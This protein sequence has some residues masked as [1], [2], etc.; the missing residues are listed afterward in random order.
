MVELAPEIVALLLLAG[1]AAGCIDA[2]A[3][4]GGLI[5]V[6]VL[7]FSGMSPVAALATN[8]LQASFGSTTAA[9]FFVRHKHIDL[10]TMWPAIM[11]AALGS[12]LGTGLIQLISTDWLMRFIP[13]LL[14]AVSVYLWCQKDTGHEAYDA[15]MKTSTFDRSFTLGIGAYDGFAGPGTGTF[16]TVTQRHYLGLSLVQ[17][18][19]RTKVLNATTNVVSLCVFILGG[20]MVWLVGLLMGAAQML[21]ARTGAALVM[22]QGATLVR[23]VSIVM[24]IVMSISL[25]VFK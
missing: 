2:I 25:L 6:P 3:G 20:H 12:A 11:L 19:A 24:C 16:F 5:T 1:F 17:A 7:L 18:T 22:T 15:R 9:R 23:G 21:G 13:V 8:K 4:G 10:T 14:I